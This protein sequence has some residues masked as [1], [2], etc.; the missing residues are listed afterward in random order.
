MPAPLK[1]FEGYD[2]SE[3]RYVRG[4]FVYVA[5]NG[6]SEPEKY[7]LT[8]MEKGPSK[9]RTSTAASIVYVLT[10]NRSQLR[11]EHKIRKETNNI[12]AIKGHQ[13]RLYGFFNENDDYVV[14]HCVRKKRDKARRPDLDKAERLY[15]EY[16]ARK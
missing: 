15:A 14:V 3:A 11:N 9:N 4:L 2:R 5:E 13:E 1:Q 10:R 8:L 16:Q 12:W 6:R 7:L